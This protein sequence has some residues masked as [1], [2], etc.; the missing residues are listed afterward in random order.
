MF[1]LII[2]SRLGGGRFF[3]FLLLFC[4][5]GGYKP[6]FGG[7]EKITANLIKKLVLVLDP[8]LLPTSDH[9]TLSSFY[10][11]H[12]GVNRPRSSKIGI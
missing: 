6:A 11:L 3:G 5:W 12:S 10:F 9:H 8:L 7:L 4:G 1:H 2:P